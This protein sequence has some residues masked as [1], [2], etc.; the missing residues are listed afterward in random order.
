V[1]MRLD[2][3]K[4]DLANPKVH[5]TDRDFAVT[6]VKMYGKGRVYYSTLGH[7][8]DNWD[9]PRL[10]QMYVEAIKWAMRMAGTDVT[11]P[12]TPP[13]SGLSH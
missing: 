1:L 5:R 7:P 11:P 2:A 8:E 12:Q 13:S 10:Q 3:S 4:L 6:W 9:D